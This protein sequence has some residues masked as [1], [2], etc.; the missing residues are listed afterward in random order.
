MPRLTIRSRPDSTCWQYDL[1][2]PGF[3]SRGSTKLPIADFTRDRAYDIMAGHL[4]AEEGPQDA[5]GSLEWLHDTLPDR[6]ARENVRDSSIERYMDALNVMIDMLGASYPVRDIARRPHVAAYQQ[7]EL[8]RGIAP[9]TVNNRL[10]YLRAIFQR[11]FDDGT[12]E[13]NPF[14]RC[15]RLRFPDPGPAVLTPDQLRALFAA[16]PDT[17]S[18][19]LCRILLFTGRRVSEIVGLERSDVDL[20]QR[21]YRPQN[22]KHRDRPKSWHSIPS[23]V[24]DDFNHFLSLPGRFPFHVRNATSLSRYFKVARERAGLSASYHLHSLRHTY[25]TM[26]LEAGA[27]PLAVQAAVDHASLRMTERYTHPQNS[28]TPCIN[29]PFVP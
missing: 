21:Q 3:R 14:M 11:L 24:M 8:A 20:D 2:A 6:L 1:T 25:I 5:P 22:I 13:V 18:K 16:M 29:L 23:Q 27:S 4:L 28:A 15:G 10:N 26:A 9:A 19:R 7:R 17:D 12:I